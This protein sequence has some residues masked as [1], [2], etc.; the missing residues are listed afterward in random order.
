MDIPA[1]GPGSIRIERE[2]RQTACSI[3]EAFAERNDRASDWPSRPTTS[4]TR[5]MA[6]PRGY[7]ADYDDD[8]SL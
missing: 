2:L 3:E 6:D 8:D 4:H 7:E 5:Q 1:P